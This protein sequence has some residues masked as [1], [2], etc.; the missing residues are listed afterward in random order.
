MTD[1]LFVY[2]FSHTAIPY[3]AFAQVFVIVTFVSGKSGPFEE[4]QKKKRR[5]CNI[6][7]GVSI[8]AYIL[9]TTILVTIKRE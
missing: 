6:Q 1:S 4:E 5:G 2:E 9:T 3:F 8:F 7:H